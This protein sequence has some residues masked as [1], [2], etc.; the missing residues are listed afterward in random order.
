[1]QHRFDSVPCIALNGP[2]TASHE[3]GLFFRSIDGVYTDSQLVSSILLG[4]SFFTLHLEDAIRCGGFDRHTERHTTT[5]GGRKHP[6]PLRCMGEA[7]P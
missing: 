1:M 6:Q 5:I 7:L 4:R 3:N 2:S